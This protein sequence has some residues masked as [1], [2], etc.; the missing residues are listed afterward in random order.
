MAGEG[1][2]RLEKII[3]GWGRVIGG[4]RRIP[5]GC[6]WSNDGWLHH[7][8]QYPSYSGASGS[9]WKKV[10]QELHKYGGGLL[11]MEGRDSSSAP[12]D[13]KQ[14]GVSSKTTTD[15]VVASN[16]S[17]PHMDVYHMG[18]GVPS[19]R[20]SGVTQ[21]LSQRPLQKWKGPD[22]ISRIYGDWI[23]DIE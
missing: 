16:L 23:D 4:W 21:R 10:R 2:K 18:V 14:G 17:V 1:R 22:K 15:T 11:E 9:V 7:G 19:Q 3:I 13:L 12:S 5:E 8:Q 6:G 20:T